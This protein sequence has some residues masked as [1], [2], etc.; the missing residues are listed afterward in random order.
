VSLLVGDH[1]VEPF[2]GLFH[3]DVLGDRGDLG[4]ILPGLLEA[5]GGKREL[6]GALDLGLLFGEGI[7]FLSLVFVR[8]LIL[9]GELGRCLHLFG[10]DVLQKI[11]LG[12]AAALDHAAHVGKR[13]DAEG[14][15]H[16]AGSHIELFLILYRKREQ[17]HEKRHQ[18]R[19]QVGK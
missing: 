13:L 10:P 12:I 1:D 7:G 14:V 17:H 3:D 19:H 4:Q 11:A 15:L 18:Q 6:G 5:G 8:G 9:G 16:R 2:L